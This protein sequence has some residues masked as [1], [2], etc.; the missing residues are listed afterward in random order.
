MV[1]GLKLTLRLR[2]TL[3]YTLLVAVVLAASGLGLHL[4]LRRNLYQSLDSSL[5]EAT[6]FLSTLTIDKEEPLK[7]QNEEG[8]FQPPVDL[9]TLLFDSSGKLIDSLGRVPA[10]LP[11]LEPGFSTWSEWRVYTEKV[12]DGTLLV[13]RD[14]KRVEESLQQFDSSFLLLSPLAVLLAFALGYLFAGRA[15][16]PVTSL[17]SAA[18]DLA[19]RRAWRETLPEPKQK[20]ELWQLTKATNTLLGTLAD[21]IE[22]ERRFTADAAHELRTPLTVLQGRLEQAL[23]RNRDT[24]ITPLLNKSATALGELLTLVEKLLLLSK[25]EAGQGLTK[26][27]VDLKEVITKTSELFRGQFE[28]KGLAFNFKPPDA[29]VIIQGD[30][31]ALGLLVRNLLENAYKFTERGEVSVTLRQENQQITLTVEDTGVGIPVEALPHLFERFYQADVRH[32]RQGSGL[33][34]ALVQSIATWHGGSVVAE[35]RSEGGSRFTVSLLST[36]QK[37]NEG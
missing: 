19:Q 20:D 30:P 37:A 22:T 32:R 10:T 9:V 27:S 29:P 13:M 16:N 5:R 34:L 12:Q 21:V 36:R 24:D 33:G 17:T 18:Y 35:N 25:T 11:P 8:A 4:L 2:L 23:E 31:V 7:L 26:E 1:T 28:Q 6:N 3:F 15:L 14:V